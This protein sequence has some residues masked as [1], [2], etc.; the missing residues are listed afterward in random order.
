MSK[1]SFRVS[2]E[3]PWVC[4]QI[5]P[6]LGAVAFRINARRNLILSD[7]SRTFLL[8][9]RSLLTERYN[10]RGFPDGSAACC[11]D[12]KTELRDY[13]V[14][15]DIRIL[16]SDSESLRVLKPLICP[17]CSKIE[18]SI[19]LN[20]QIV[21]THGISIHARYVEKHE[22]YCDS[23]VL[24]TVSVKNHSGPPLFLKTDDVS[25]EENKRANIDGE[26]G[27]T[28]GQAGSKRN[29]EEY[30]SQSQSSANTSGYDDVF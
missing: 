27:I 26:V 10:T 25:H 1:M 4:L 28:G 13:C 24:D 22:K 16:N 21:E 12:S 8:T 3:I 20:C 2:L 17:M 29:R 15:A 23:L 11:I 18:E 14:E 7:S 19:M 9:Q 6:V 30:I 5:R